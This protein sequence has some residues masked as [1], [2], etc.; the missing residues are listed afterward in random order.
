MKISLVTTTIN[1][2]SFLYDFDKCDAGNNDV[3]FII[4][5]DN[6]TPNAVERFCNRQSFDNFRVEY[7]TPELQKHYIKEYWKVNNVGSVIPENDIR[8]RNFGFLRAWE[9]DSDYVVSLDD[10]NYPLNN[11]WLS[12]VLE[13]MNSIPCSV[14]SN[15]KVFNPCSY[16]Y[17]SE[18]FCY[19]RGFP[20]SLWFRNDYCTTVK[21]GDRKIVMNQMLWENKPDVDAVTNLIFPD[22]KTRK[23]N[24]DGN[25]NVIVSKDNY[26]P[27]DTQS[28]IISKELS[29]FHALYQ[30]PLFNLPSHRYDDIWAGLFSQK[31]IHQMGDACSF[32]G[33]VM[34]HRRNT[35]NF[36]KDLQMEFVGM[37]LNEKMWSHV[38]NLD[39]QSKDYKSGLL[40][41]ADSLP[42]AFK[43][44]DYKVVNFMEKIQ[45]S[46]HI[47]VNLLEKIS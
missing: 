24:L 22:L 43:E 41:I 15:L 19:S 18:D 7:W 2:P 47:W 14:D 4:V 33:P 28:I 10:D 29:V 5:G 35:H 39:L 23:I 16:L 42:E 21:S 11:T 31:L 13:S 45:D 34:E 20:Q 36:Q 38:M 25:Y 37:T 12:E 40:E 1:V 9:L 6:K 32:G 30:Q 26:F 27:V 17:S 44:Y 8:R 46:C 3:V